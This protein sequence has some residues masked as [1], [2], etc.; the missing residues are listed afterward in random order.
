MVKS[1]KAVQGDCHSEK[2]VLCEGSSTGDVELKEGCALSCGMAGS[3]THAN[4]RLCVLS[5]LSNL[6][7]PKV[8]YMLW[9]QIKHKIPCPSRIKF[10]GRQCHEQPWLFAAH[11]GWDFLESEMPWR[12]RCL[13]HV[14]LSACQRCFFSLGGLNF[15]SC[16]HQSS[17]QPLLKLEVATQAPCQA[18][19]RKI[20][21]SVMVLCFL[22]SFA[23]AAF[24]F[25]AEV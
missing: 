10:G 13:H 9:C 14:D 15:A 23:G 11:Q 7:K 22:R 25:L 1:F 20:H 16:C 4:L 3:K 24:K 2:S 8:Q 12:T 5:P 19:G 21:T 18:P 6:P 17:L